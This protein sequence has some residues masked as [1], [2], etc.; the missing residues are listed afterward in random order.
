MRAVVAR[1]DVE[2]THGQPD[3]HSSLAP[4]SRREPYA[5]LRK[6]P[7]YSNAVGLPVHY[8]KFL[9][10]PHIGD[11]SNSGRIVRRIRPLAPGRSL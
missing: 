6:L 3:R 8:P 11:D 4:F 9:A 1:D 5:Q 2:L 7:A 10:V